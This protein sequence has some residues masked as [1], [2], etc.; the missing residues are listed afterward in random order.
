MV[1]R[2]EQ[3]LRSALA[4]VTLLLLVVV[5]H[6]KRRRHHN[7]TIAAIHK[8][9]TTSDSR[10]STLV[11]PLVFSASRWPARRLTLALTAAVILSFALGYVLLDGASASFAH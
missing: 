9:F 6:D 4:R 7:T 10:A 11:A 1:D 3:S 5:A 2:N 8:R